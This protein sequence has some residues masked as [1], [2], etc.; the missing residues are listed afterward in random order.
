MSEQPVISVVV[1][2]RN[3]GAKLAELVAALDRQTVSAPFEAIIVD[4]GSTDGAAAA[5][6]SR[7]WLRVV[8]QAPS[9]SYAARNRGCLEARADVLAF[10]DAD[11][12]P[13]SD[14]LA[15]ALAAITGADIVAGRIEMPPPERPTVWTYVEADDWRDQEL[16]LSRGAAETANLIVRR[17]WFERSGRF[18]E[19]LPSGGDHDFVR[20]A[21]AFGARTAYAPN[22]VVLHDARGSA[23]EYLTAIW[24]RH[25]AVGYRAALGADPAHG[26]PQPRPRS[27]GPASRAARM[28]QAYFPDVR[29]FLARRR[30]GRP[31]LPRS[32]SHESYEPSAAEKVVAL[33]VL[34][35]LLP[36]WARSASLAGRLAASRERATRQ[37]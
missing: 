1:P 11:C 37:P 32:E 2:A 34:Y 18:D 21:V 4:D 7:P 23:R 14:W 17:S 12:R 26:T 27:R 9:N 22:A 28:L 36:M 20:R 15:E 5:L 35:W 24:Q 10:T 25:R 8:R 33:V 31:V 6:P 30:A 13:T 19:S 29:R 16:A 3:A